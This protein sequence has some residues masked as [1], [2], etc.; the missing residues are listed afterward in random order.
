MF[1]LFKLLY[2]HLL[3]RSML[4]I[5][6]PQQVAW[7][8]KN[9]TLY[10]TVFERYFNAGALLIQWH[11]FKKMVKFGKLEAQPG[12]RGTYMLVLKMDNLLGYLLLGIC[13]S[14]GQTLRMYITCTL[15]FFCY[16]VKLWLNYN[17][18]YDNYR[19]CSPVP[20]V[21]LMAIYV[22][23]SVTSWTIISVNL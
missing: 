13:C 20:T 14:K 6:T 12:F 21:N 10:Q 5:W 18:N 11:R 15:S 4:T 3:C 7:D 23:S 9:G 17:C 1:V 22:A 16:A 19:P 8:L 2:T